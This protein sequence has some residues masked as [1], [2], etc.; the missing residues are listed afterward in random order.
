LGFGSIFRI[1]ASKILVI[2]SPS[3]L[4]GN[5]HP[6]CWNLFF[7]SKAISLFLMCTDWFCRPVKFFRS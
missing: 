1:R 7:L 5:R 3:L 6:F 4:E 2:D